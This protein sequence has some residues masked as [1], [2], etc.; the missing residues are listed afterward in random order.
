MKKKEVLLDNQKYIGD[1][2]TYMLFI[3]FRRHLLT[4]VIF[5]HT[6]SKINLVLR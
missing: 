4:K 6:A 3:K 1:K 5:Q 2:V